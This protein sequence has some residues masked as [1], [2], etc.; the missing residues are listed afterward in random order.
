MD[1]IR[2]RRTWNGIIKKEAPEYVKKQ[3]EEYKKA[4]K[5]HGFKID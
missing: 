5:K 2:Q 3:Y 4:R 1:N